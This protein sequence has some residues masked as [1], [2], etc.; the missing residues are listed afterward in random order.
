[1]RRSA[2]SALTGCYTQAKSLDEL[3]ERIQEAI[4][5]RIRFKQERYMQSPTNLKELL[6]EEIDQVPEVLL[7]ELLDFL[8]FLKSKHLQAKLEVS[9]LS[10]SSLQKDWLRPEEDEA[11]QDL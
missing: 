8:Q 3:M 2:V 7:V 1:M 4:A 10:T 11:W 5:L 9:A 6:L